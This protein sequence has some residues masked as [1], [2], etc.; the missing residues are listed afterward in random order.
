MDI[1]QRFESIRTFQEGSAPSL[2]KPVMLL[3]A[4]SNCYRGDNRMMRFSQFDN[5]FKNLFLG[6]NL[7]GKFE[8]SHYPFGK[9]ENDGIWEI[10]NSKNLKRTSVGHLHKNELLEKEI[11]GGFTEEI[12]QSLSSD[13]ALILSVAHHLLDKYFPKDQHTLLISMLNIPIR[14]NKMDL[15]NVS[16]IN[17]EKQ[18]N[19]NMDLNIGVEKP[20]TARRNGYVAYL[21][22]LHNIAANGANALAES[23]ALNIYF[24]EIYQ[25]FP[26]VK[27]IYQA[28]IG[29]KEQVVILTG[30]AGD[31]KSTVALDVLKQLRQIP[32][33]KPLDYALKEIEETN[34]SNGKVT[35]VKDMSEL[36]AQQRLDWL[37]QGFTQPGSW[38]IVS[39]T[40]PLINSLADYVS[41]I[42]GP[43]DI[44][45]NILE[46]LDRP[47]EN[48]N[49]DQHVVLGFDKE[50]VVLNMTR[51]DNVFLGAKVLTKMVNH[52]AWEGC[53]GCEVEASCPVR[54]NQNALQAASETVEERVS[55]IYRRLTSYEQRLTLRQ[56]VAHLALSLTGGMSCEEAHK[57]VKN[58]THGVND[59]EVEALERTLFSEVFFGYRRGEPWAAA[60]SLR[61]ISLIKRS[62]FG[63]PTAVD[64]ERQLLVTGG[65][66]GMTL[67]DTLTKT[68]QHW[69]KRAGEAAGVRWRFALRRMLYLFGRETSPTKLHS[70]E[71]LSTFLHSPKLRD[72]NRWQSEA[73][74]TLENKEKRALK[75]RCLQVLLE[76]YSGF[77]SGQ[78][79]GD[80]ALYLTLRRPDRIVIQPTQ[81]IVAKLDTQDF[82]LCYDTSRRFPKLV[83]KDELAELPLTLP[84]LDYI[85]CRSIGQL[86]NELA[87]IHLAQLEW[88][89]AELLNH[90]NSFPSGVIGLLRSGID[91][92][93]K[94]YRF[95]IDGQKQ[96]LEK[97]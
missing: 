34:H 55:W 15:L 40:G 33:D 39:N 26:V 91:G 18:R 89:R 90:A 24:T 14:D 60:E 2:H 13:K 56:M 27:D 53:H 92:K 48:G 32:L 78:F 67:P 45:S 82:S 6:L 4:L 47:Y 21:N 85:Q 1:F 28:L 88:F 9:L 71:F 20:M 66:N 5:E 73:G 38:L 50:L 51:L 46:C 65:V 84:L 31:G 57:F 49:L 11:S 72:Y 76:I 63:G 42:S 59:S 16:E 25:A 70:Q 58:S 41:K 62:V 77:S 94:M 61:A 17:I 75:N 64:F 43:I 10:E 81:L 83:Y 29:S 52:S 3:I 12:F 87:P 96:E 36:T 30:H 54:I 97:Y 7:E 23:Q 68:Q 95:E 69:R 86:G 35:I 19:I 44:E 8:N 79:E 74:L 93:V 22:S 37:E 80:D